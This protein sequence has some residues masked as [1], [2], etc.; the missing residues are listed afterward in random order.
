MR[1]NPAKLRSGGRQRKKGTIYSGDLRITRFFAVFADAAFFGGAVKKG[2][3]Y[4]PGRT[5][6]FP[7]INKFF[8]IFSVLFSITKIIFAICGKKI[9]FKWRKYEY[10]V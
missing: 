5:R 1:I 9:G 4:R 8:L 10:V 3:Y 6:A 7:T 2:N